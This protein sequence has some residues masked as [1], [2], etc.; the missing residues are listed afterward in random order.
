MID[1]VDAATT[2]FE[3]LPAYREIVG[4]KGQR[5]YTGLW[6]FATSRTHVPYESWVERDYVM[7]L[8]RS[9][10]VVAVRSQPFGLAVTLAAS[11]KWHVPDYFVRLS[12]GGCR[13][14]DVRPKSLITSEDQRTF[15][16]TGQLYKMVGWDYEVVG[17][18]SPVLR[19][20]LRW[21]AAYRHP[22][23]ANSGVSWDA[24]RSAVAERGRVRLSTLPQLLDVSPMALLP[25]VYYRLWT[26]D[27]SVDIARLL[28]LRSFVEVG[29]A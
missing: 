6:W 14:V 3:E 4:F 7:V 23:N 13:V 15:D 28:S 22:R 12:D 21:I 11:P 24:L 19:S 20:N 16:A 9:P 18:L 25:H 17:D 26:G 5:N 2:R 29:S 10:D 1:L 27:L 8:D